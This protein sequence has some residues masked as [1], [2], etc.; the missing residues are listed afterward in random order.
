[1][2]LTPREKNVKIE[3]QRIEFYS[4]LEDT[5]KKIKGRSAKGEKIFVN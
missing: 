3:F 1:M 4:T 2:T 5:M